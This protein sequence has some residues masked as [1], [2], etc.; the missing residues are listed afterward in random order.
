MR[1]LDFLRRALDPRSEDGLALVMALLILVFLSA[2]TATAM[3]MATSSSATAT[4]STGQQ[5]AYAL[6]QAGINN[7]EAVL[8]SPSNNPASPTLLSTP[9]TNTYTN[10]AGVIGT[11]TST[12][13]GTFNAGTSTWTISSTSTVPNVAGGTPITRT[14]TATVPITITNNYQPNTNAWN[15]IVATK[16]SNSSTCD[17]TIGESSVVDVPVYVFGNLCIDKQAGIVEASGGQAINLTVLGK[18]AFIGDGT[19]HIGCRTSMGFA[20]CSSNSSVT[21]AHLVGGCY[22]GPAP[23]GTTHTCSSS[24]DHVWATTLDSTATTL[25]A[26]TASFSTYYASAAPGPNHGCTTSSG[27]VP[28][29]DNNSTM[30]NS[31]PSFELTPSSSDYSCV[32]KDSNGNTIGQLSWNHTTRGLTVS[33]VIFIDGSA[34]VSDVGSGTGLNTYSGSGVLYLSGSLSMIKGA[35]LCAVASGQNCFWSGTG[36]GSWNPNSQMLSIITNGSTAAPDGTSSGI[37]LN[38]SNQLQASLYATNGIYLG[39]NGQAEGPMVCGSIDM[40][41]PFTA[42]PFPSITSLPSGMPGS[43]NAT[44][45]P[46]TPTYTNS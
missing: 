1:R 7:A 36:T 13:S 21:Q 35:E 19:G 30:D 27:T 15:W 6:A 23:L 33:G 3:T 25:N 14:L 38:E 31:A 41:K 46:G 44:A 10:S 28:T 22:N 39:K 5:A 24:T 29:W 8:N 9:V 26:P 18:T 34:T 12:W 11:G 20:N 37:I 16:T 4:Q 43:L 17:S 40:I 2:A 45:V 42:K 32:A